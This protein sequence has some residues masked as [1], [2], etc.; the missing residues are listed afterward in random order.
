[1]PGR[2]PAG[3]PS[4][5]LAGGPARA[6][7][8]VADGE[9]VADLAQPQAQALATL[10][11]LQAVDRVV[12]VGAV[13]GRRAVR[14]G[15]Q[16]GPLVVADG[17][18]GDARDRGQFGNPQPATADGGGLDHGPTVN[19]GANSKVKPQLPGATAR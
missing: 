11:E 6:R 4:Q 18:G 1:L 10:D 12:V 5:Q 2:T 9:Q 3:R 16:S 14:S 8:G 7:S 19:L 15:Q 17:V 13:A